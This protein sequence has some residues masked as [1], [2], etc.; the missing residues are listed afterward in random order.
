MRFSPQPEY[1]LGVLTRS[2]SPDFSNVLK[3]S[4]I[5]RL[6]EADEHEVVREVQV[7]LS[8]SLQSLGTEAKNRAQEYFADY[9]PITTSHF[10]LNINPSPP[11]SIPTTTTLSSLMDRPGP[12]TR[13]GADRYTAL[14]G[15]S[16]S[17]WNTTTDA[18]ES[19]VQGLMALLLSLKKKPVI[20]YER[21]SGMGRKLGQELLVRVVSGSTDLR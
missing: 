21:M 15:D 4:E 20:R 10:S 13:R 16:P 6:A 19:H 14:Y 7:G 3:K 11:S 8:S 1:L 12:S 18:L 17:A 5:E 2:M 9:A